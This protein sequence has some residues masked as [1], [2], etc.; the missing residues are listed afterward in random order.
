MFNEISRL[1]REIHKFR[2]G[3]QSKIDKSRIRNYERE[4]RLR[5]ENGAVVPGY[6]QFK[7]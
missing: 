6:R 7:Q 3:D 4:I 2:F 1:A 5:L